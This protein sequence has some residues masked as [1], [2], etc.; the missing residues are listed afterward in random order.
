MRSASKQLE[1]E[2]GAAEREIDISDK[3]SQVR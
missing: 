1:H 2:S 3:M